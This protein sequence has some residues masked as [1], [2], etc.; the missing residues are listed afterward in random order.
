MIGAVV[1]VCNRRDNLELLLAS[2]QAQTVDDFPVVVAD[3]GSTDGTRE[4]VEDLARLQKWSRRLRWIGC[5]PG[6]GV[7]T[8][9]ARNISAA[10]LPA[11]VKGTFTGPELRGI[12]SVRLP[13]C[14]RCAR[15][16]RCH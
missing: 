6:L 15:S 12:S 9:R 4:L 14:Y 2:L 5:G 10:N 3:D 8:G 13:P 11:G 16:G 1:P 7:R